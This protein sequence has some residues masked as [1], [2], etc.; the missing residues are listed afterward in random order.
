MLGGTG[1]V[2]GGEF[3][4]EDNPLRWRVGRVGRFFLDQ[5]PRINPLFPP[6]VTRAPRNRPPSTTGSTPLRAI[7]KARATGA[8]LDAPPP[9]LC[10]THIPP[11]RRRLHHLPGPYHTRARTDAPRTHTHH[12]RT[13]RARSHK[14]NKYTHKAQD[15]VAVAAASERRAFEQRRPASAASRWRAALVDGST[16]LRWWWPPRRRRVDRGRAASRRRPEDRVHD[17]D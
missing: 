5:P 7:C 12:A 8:P 11:I 14:H 10:S 13:Y 6:T 17:D 1:G 3:L 2:S 9:P 4:D 15:S 16:E